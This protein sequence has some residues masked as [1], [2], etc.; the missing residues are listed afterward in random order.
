MASY[1]GSKIFLTAT[2]E[3]LRLPLWR[4]MAPYGGKWRHLKKKFFLG[5]VVLVNIFGLTEPIAFRF[6]Y[7]DIF[8]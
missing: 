8:R 3:H 7:L 5:I 1:I 6:A 2:V 4:H